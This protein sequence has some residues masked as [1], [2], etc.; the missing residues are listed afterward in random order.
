MRNDLYKYV[1]LFLS[2]AEGKK[3][4]PNK[5]AHGRISQVIA[6]V[7]DAKAGRITSSLEYR[8]HS[9][10]EYKKIGEEERRDLHQ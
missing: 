8:F 10:P 3:K 6:T 4:G 9:I 5:L 2:I 1:A 7:S